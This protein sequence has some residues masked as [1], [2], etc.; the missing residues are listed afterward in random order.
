MTS[1]SINS[2]YVCPPSDLSCL[3]DQKE[4]LDSFGLELGWVGIVGF[5]SNHSMVEFWMVSWVSGESETTI[6][7]GVSG[8]SD[9]WSLIWFGWIAGSSLVT[10]VIGISS[11][12][13]TWPA[14][15]WSFKFSWISGTFSFFFFLGLEAFSI[16][17]K[18][19]LKVELSA[20]FYFKSGSSEGDDIRI[21]KE[22]I[23]S[24]VSGIFKCCSSS[25]WNIFRT[26]GFLFSAVIEKATTGYNFSK[27]S[28]FSEFYT[29]SLISG[30]FRSHTNLS[31][32][33]SIT[34]RIL[35]FYHWF[36]RRYLDH[37][38]EFLQFPR[39][40]RNFPGFA[41]AFWKCSESDKT[42]RYFFFWESWTLS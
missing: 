10:S 24:G 7:S 38:G 20:I 33:I 14:N 25:F 4:L 30:D 13:G 17:S 34:P 22:S 27:L 9:F 28:E 29:Q 26:G 8:F 41:I 6:F 19:D 42:A 5:E 12:L 39:F 15:S 11:L 1:P 35:I 21:F 37:T 16:S 36:L 2:C 3:M 32:L 40:S 31:E 23:F 18:M